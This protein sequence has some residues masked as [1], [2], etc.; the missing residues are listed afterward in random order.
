MNIKSSQFRRCHF[1]IGVFR[2]NQDGP[3]TFGYRT[4][5]KRPGGPNVD[6]ACA[7]RLRTCALVHFSVD[8]FQSNAADKFQTNETH[9]CIAS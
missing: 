1:P 7:S 8:V 3:S 9:L 6:Q 2:L 4:P 5:Q